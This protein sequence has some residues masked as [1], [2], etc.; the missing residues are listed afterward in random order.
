MKKSPF[1]RRYIITF[2]KLTFTKYKFQSESNNEVIGQQL[3]WTAVVNSGRYKKAVDLLKVAKILHQ[4]YQKFDHVKFAIAMTLADIAKIVGEHF[5]SPHFLPVNILPPS[6]QTLQGLQADQLFLLLKLRDVLGEYGYSCKKYFKNGK[7]L[8]KDE[9]F[10]DII[11][12]LKTTVGAIEKFALSDVV[13][14]AALDAGV[15]MK[16]F[17]EIF[18]PAFKFDNLTEKTKHNSE[19][20]WYLVMLVKRWLGRNILS[21]ED[22]KAIFSDSVF[23]KKLGYTITSDSKLKLKNNHL[24]HITALVTELM[25]Y[26]KHQNLSS[27]Q[28]V[29]FMITVHDV[30]EDPE[31][32]AF[33]EKSDFTMKMLGLLDEDAMEIL[34]NKVFS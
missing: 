10:P 29:D 15:S 4:H 22:C 19:S 23:L 30:Q 16:V 7:F 24:P 32:D 3:F 6:L 17:K 18:Y 13:Y 14:K 26:L 8:F 9:Y 1:K 28:L 2:P 25:G 27:D 11:A 31:I 12:I 21:M 33:F 34:I 5:F 20:Y